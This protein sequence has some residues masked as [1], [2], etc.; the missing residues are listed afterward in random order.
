MLLLR[1]IGDIQNSVICRDYVR[2][3]DS[4]DGRLGQ[5]RH[6]A[7][8]VPRQVETHWLYLA[9]NTGELVADFQ[10]Q[11]QKEIYEAWNTLLLWLKLLIW[12]V[13]EVLLNNSL[14][15]NKN[16]KCKLHLDGVF[17]SG[18]KLVICFVIP[19]WRKADSE[20]ECPACADLLEADFHRGCVLRYGTETGFSS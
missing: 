20:A 15:A 14:K 2:A 16:L 17:R 7:L 4:T 11:Y 13:L 9:G 6:E 19:I 1:Q 3:S 18:A 8:G 10:G 12:A 5:I